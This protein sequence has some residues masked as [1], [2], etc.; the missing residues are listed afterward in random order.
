M[1][2]N[3]KKDTNQ[4][5][6]VPQDKFLQNLLKSLLI[7]PGETSKQDLQYLIWFVLLKMTCS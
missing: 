6:D 4:I 5:N 7:V 2:E 1:A 3:D